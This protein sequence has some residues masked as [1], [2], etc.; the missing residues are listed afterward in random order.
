MPGLSGKILQRINT[1][2]NRDE[3]KLIDKPETG[4]TTLCQRRK[5]HQG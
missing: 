2:E 5:I 4:R 1:S 3:E